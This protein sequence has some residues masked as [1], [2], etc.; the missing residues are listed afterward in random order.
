MRL[1]LIAAVLA[2]AG[3]FQPVDPNARVI[4]SCKGACPYGECDDQ[5]TPKDAGCST[6]EDCLRVY[7]CSK[8]EARSCSAYKP[9]SFPVGTTLPTC[10]QVPGEYC[11]TTIGAYGASK[12]LAIECTDAGEVETDCSSVDPCAD[13]GASPGAC[14]TACGPRFCI[15]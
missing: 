3:C 7:S 4:S 14:R 15:R 6:P 11:V 10:A 13:G 5:C 2:L 9:E 8:V 1:S 12:R